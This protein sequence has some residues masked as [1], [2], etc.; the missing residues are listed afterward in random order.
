MCMYVPSW[1]SGFSRC[2]SDKLS[3]AIA[4]ESSDESRERSWP[5]SSEWSTFSGR[6]PVI[7]PLGWDT[8][9]T[10]TVENETNE[11]E[12]DDDKHFEETEEEFGLSV[13]LDPEEIDCFAVISM[14][15]PF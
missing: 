10:S 1:V 6:F 5:S 7:K 11:D 8:T 2:K 13:P 9:D 3:S 12:D 4:Q 15:F 14:C